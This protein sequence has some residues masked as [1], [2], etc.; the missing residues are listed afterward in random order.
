MNLRVLGVIIDFILIFLNYLFI[1]VRIITYYVT[2]FVV[3][4]V[5]APVGVIVNDVRM[6]K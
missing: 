1:E 5:H 6:G 2:C 3:D 4:N